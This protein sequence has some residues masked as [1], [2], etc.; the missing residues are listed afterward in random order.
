MKMIT[1]SYKVIQN[2]EMIEEDDISEFEVISTK[3]D[4]K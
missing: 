2:K 3:E 1:I 4:Q